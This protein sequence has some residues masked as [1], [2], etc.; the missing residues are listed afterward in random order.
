MDTGSPL[1]FRSRTRPLRIPHH[2]LDASIFDV[3]ALRFCDE[4]GRPLRQCTL[5][6]FSDPLPCFRQP[7]WSAGC[8]ATGPP[9]P[10]QSAAG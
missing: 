9:A 10:W 7:L 2:V 3:M 6:A 5:L 1:L 8:A 4:S